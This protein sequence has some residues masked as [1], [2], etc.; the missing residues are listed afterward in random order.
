MAHRD[1]IVAWANELLDSASFPDYGPNGLQVV[2]GETVTHIA[3]AVSCTRSVFEQ[4]ASHGAQLLITHHGLIW[5]GQIDC[6]DE[7]WRGRLATLFDNGI[8]LASWH[9]PLDAH[10]QIG[11]NAILCE[12]L[13]LTRT[14]LEFAHHKGRVIGCVGT[15]GQPRSSVELAS[16]L[17]ALTG[18]EPQVLGADRSDISTVA[19]CS[20]GAASNVAEAARLGADAF[21]TGEPNEPAHAWATEAGIAFIAAGHYATETF[22]VRALGERIAGQFDVE[23]SF[24]ADANP[25]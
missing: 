24:I 2:G 20:G 8:S 1:D 12:R 10:P 23:H 25:V 5:D 9:L 11:N 18:R 14:A 19:I 7:V 17:G 3:T 16:A 4:A 15:W 13:E 22:G 6:F 21:V